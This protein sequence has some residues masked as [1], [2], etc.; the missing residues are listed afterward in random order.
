M[1]IFFLSRVEHVALCVFLTLQSLH[2][3]YLFRRSNYLPTCDEQSDI[4]NNVNVAMLNVEGTDIVET[5]NNP[6]RAGS[7]YHD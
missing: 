5:G 6:P 4:F 1:N 3:S 2:V 7:S